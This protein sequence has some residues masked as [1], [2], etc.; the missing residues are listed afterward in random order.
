M[1]HEKLSAL[2]RKSNV[3]GKGVGRISAKAASEKFSE[4][5]KLLPGIVAETMPNGE[6]R[7]RV[8][9]AG[10]PTKKTGIPKRLNNE[11]FMQAYWDAR[12]GKKTDFTKP[13]IVPFSERKGFARAI[14]LMFRGAQQRAALKKLECSITKADLIKLVDEQGGRCAVTGVEFNLSPIEEGKK[15]PNRMSVDRIDRRTGY[16]PTNIRITTAIA[17][18]AMM[19]WEFDDFVRMCHAVAK[20]HRVPRDKKTRTPPSPALSP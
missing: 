2:L 20:Q 12:K 3:T 18:I 17:N 9:Q 13:E 6:V 19:D 7:V 14:S 4:L 5:K 16:T 8:R 1:Y 10:D 11:Q 15:R